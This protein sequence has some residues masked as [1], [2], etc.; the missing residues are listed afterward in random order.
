MRQ[1]ATRREQAPTG[2]RRAEQAAARWTRELLPRL[3]LPDGDATVSVPPAA[4]PPPERIPLRR[5][6]SIDSVLREVWKF[7]PREVTLGRERSRGS[8]LPARQPGEPGPP[9][10]G[11]PT[12]RRSDRWSSGPADCAPGS[13]P[14]YRER[15]PATF[16][17]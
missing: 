3:L 10:P 8:C 14:R 9:E 7:E 1:A 12:A 2:S 17:G 4:L 16:S 15:A 13:A 6:A 11:P 5:A